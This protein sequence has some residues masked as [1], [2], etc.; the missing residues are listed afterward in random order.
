MT[1]I[2]IPGYRIQGVLGDGAMATVYRAVHEGLDKQVALKVLHED[3]ATDDEYRARFLREGRAAA[4]FNHPNLVRAYEAGEHAGRFYLSMEL[5]EG[6]DLSTRLERERRLD[7]DEALRIGVEVA[8]ALAAAAA[9]GMVHR[10]VKAE[11]VLLGSDGAVKLADLGLAKV[12]GE[13]SLT[14]EGFTMG[15]VAYFSPE[16]CRGRQDLDVRTDL[17]SLGVL[18][19]Y[20]LAGELPFGRGENPIV[21]MEQILKEDARP[22]DGPSPATIRAI[23]ALLAKD[24]DDRPAS[25]E[26]AAALLADARARIGQP[27]DEPAGASSGERAGAGAPRRRRRRG[28]PRLLRTSG[29]QSTGVPALVFVA[30]VVLALVIVLALRSSGQEAWAAGAAPRA[31]ATR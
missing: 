23:A 20:A 19:H 30:L 8:R 24:R 28:R 31:E 18:L 22:L 14:R 13:G 25:A 12:Q 1:A 4:R 15:T 6:E 10:D 5:V 2:H 27:E 9:H 7:E 26:E 11:N 3:V 17:Y 21:T 16:Q 29:E